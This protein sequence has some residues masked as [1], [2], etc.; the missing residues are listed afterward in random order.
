MA[1]LSEQEQIRRN[2]LNELKKLGIKYGLE[3]SVIYPHSFRHRFAKLPKTQVSTARLLSVSFLKV[4][5]Q[6][7]ATMLRKAFIPI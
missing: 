6:T 7:M 1:E 5:T 3:P 4:K 2:S